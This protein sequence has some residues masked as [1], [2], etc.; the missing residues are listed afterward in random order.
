[1]FEHLTRLDAVVNRPYDLWYDDGWS[2]DFESVEGAITPRTRAVLVVSPNNPTGSYVKRD[3]LDRLARICQA[4]GAAIVS[5][6]VFADYELDAGRAAAA[7]RLLDRDDAL[8]FSLGGL[9]KSIGLPQ[10]KLAWIAVG[11]PGVLVDQVLQ[12]LEMACDTYLSVSTPAQAAAAELFRRGEPVRAQIHAR[13]MANYHHLTKLAA[14]VPSCRVLR[15][16][17]GWYGVLRVPSLGTEEDLVLELLERDGVLTHPGYF[18]DF[19]RETY[20]VVSLIVPEAVFAEGVSR[21]LRRFDHAVTC[22]ACDA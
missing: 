5:D 19:A 20:F 22:H 17:G 4:S 3:E 12:R 16:E 10:V 21:L 13:V 18:F 7:G 6:E 1:L 14:T 2:I 15:S 11:G 9:S 8:V